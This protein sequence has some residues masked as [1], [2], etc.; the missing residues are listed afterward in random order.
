MISSLGWTERA[1]STAANF[2][3]ISGWGVVLWWRNRRN[4]VGKGEREEGANN[5]CGDKVSRTPDGGGI[6]IEAD[7]NEI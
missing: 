4:S 1:G 3:I 6:V 2:I 7:F 5:G